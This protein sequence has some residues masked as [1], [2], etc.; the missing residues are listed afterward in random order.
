MVIWTSGDCDPCLQLHY[1]NNQIILWLINTKE[2][3]RVCVVTNNWES[4]LYLPRWEH[5]RFFPLLGGYE[6]ARRIHLRFKEWSRRMESFWVSGPWPPPSSHDLK[7]GAYCILFEHLFGYSTM[8]L[9]FL[10]RLSKSLVRQKLP[11]VLLQVAPDFPGKVG[12]II[13]H[14]YSNKQVVQL[15]SSQFWLDRM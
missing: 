6:I 13:D 5:S 8:K 10:K 7:H 3:Q 9:L 4:Q 12:C 2:F 1:V 11:Q 14:T 15:I